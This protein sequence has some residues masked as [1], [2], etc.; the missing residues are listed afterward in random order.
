MAAATISPDV[1]GLGGPGQLG[2]AGQPDSAGQPDG[3]GQPDDGAGG[4]ADPAAA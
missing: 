2:G 4:M 1:A 3:A